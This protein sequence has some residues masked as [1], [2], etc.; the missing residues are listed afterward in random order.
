VFT[1][2]QLV[3]RRVQLSLDPADSAGGQLV[4]ALGPAQLVAA[5]GRPRVACASARST[6]GSLPMTDSAWQTIADPFGNTFCRRCRRSVSGSGHVFD[7]LV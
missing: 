1:T 7:M 2:T 3:A 6:R 4:F 5:C